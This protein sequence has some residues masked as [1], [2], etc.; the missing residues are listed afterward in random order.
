MTREDIIP[1][2][3][4]FVWGAYRNVYYE[5]LIIFN[6][7]KPLGLD[8]RLQYEGRFAHWP[9]RDANLVTECDWQFREP[10]SEETEW[11]EACKE[12]GAFIPRKD[13]IPIIN[14]SYSII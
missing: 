6:S 7:S 4:Y 8:Y 3:L 10:T 12:K 13:I 9:Y 11:F 2:K 5:S 1:G 14:N